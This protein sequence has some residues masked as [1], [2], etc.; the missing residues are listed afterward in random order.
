MW[1]RADVAGPRYGTER[2]VYVLTSH[3][4]FSAAEDFSYAMKNLRRATLV[5]EVTGGGAHP[6]D[7]RRLDTHFGAFIPM[8]RSISPV[9]HTDWEGTGVEPDVKAAAKDALNVAQ[10]LILQERLASEKDPAALERMRARL[11]ELR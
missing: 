3:D 1:T 5:G 6:G 10:T 7:M 2:K 8:G 9:T 11:Q 4:T